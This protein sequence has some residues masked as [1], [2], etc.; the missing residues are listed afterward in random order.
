MEVLYDPDDPSQF[1]LDGFSSQAL[2]GKIFL[3][4]GLVSVAVGVIVGLAV[5]MIPGGIHIR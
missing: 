2:V 1:M 4:I 3:I 5:N